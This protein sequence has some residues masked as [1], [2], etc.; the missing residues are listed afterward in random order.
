MKTLE[1][2]I[3]LTDGVE[4]NCTCCALQYNCDEDECLLKDAVHYL[5]EYRHIAT[6]LNPTTRRERLIN[7]LRE[8]RGEK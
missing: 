6:S 3:T 1:E 7:A 2:V 8:V 4:F 5:K